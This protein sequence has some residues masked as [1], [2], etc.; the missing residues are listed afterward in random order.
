MR[1]RIESGGRQVIR[2][3]ASLAENRRPLTEEG[4]RLE[5]RLVGTRP[6]YSNRSR[7]S[8]ETG[9]DHAVVPEERHRGDGLPPRGPSCRGRSGRKRG[10]PRPRGPT[11]WTAA[12][13][14]APVRSRRRSPSS[15][16][17][18]DAA[19]VWFFQIQ[20][21]ARRS[22]MRPSSR[23]FLC[24]PCKSSRAPS[25]ITP[26]NQLSDPEESLSSSRRGGVSSCLWM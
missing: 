16:E 24:W 14:R 21:F 26:G 13:I 9:S 5:V 10:P 4:V 3:T 23:T 25:E 7:Y 18:G 8:H 17:C 1:L 20:E 12:I 19:S 6:A 11:R 15:F 2:C 22:E